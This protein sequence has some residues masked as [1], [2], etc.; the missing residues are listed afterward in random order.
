MINSRN[1]KYILLHLSE[2]TQAGR[3]ASFIKA[4]DIELLYS[5]YNHQNHTDIQVQ[6]TLLSTP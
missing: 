6:I 4:P 3:I 2:I 5:K 1:I